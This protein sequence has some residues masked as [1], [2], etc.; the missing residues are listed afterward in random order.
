MAK[1]PLNLTEEEREILLNILFKEMDKINELNATMQEHL[2]PYRQ[3]IRT[4]Y[5]KVVD[6]MDEDWPCKIKLIC[7]TYNI[8]N[9]RS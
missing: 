6:N 2:E 4:I 9:K 8:Q 7:Y 1:E 3:E 5:G